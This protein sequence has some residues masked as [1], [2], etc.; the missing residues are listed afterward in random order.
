MHNKKI[1]FNKPHN[2][3]QGLKPLA[4]SIPH[5]LKKILKK[6]GY[7]FTNIVD[8]WSKIV[9]KEISSHCYPYTIK[10]GKN[11]KNGKLII[12]VIH[13]KELEVEYSKNII[14]DNINS[15]FGYNYVSEVKLKV[16]QGRKEVVK[17]MNKSSPHNI[18]FE[19]K[20][21]SIQNEKLKTSLNKLIDA[22]NIKYS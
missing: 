21:E 16:I 8:N 1:N 12:N 6:N 7:N 14:I 18:K 10:I 13:G 9:G 22:F 17:N 3:I 19:K 2:F 20:L 5:G 4:N 15:F 11:V